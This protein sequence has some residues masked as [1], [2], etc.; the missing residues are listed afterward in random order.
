MTGHTLGFSE[1]QNMASVDLQ[2]PLGH[3]SN[4]VRCL[5]ATG[6]QTAIA[7]PQIQPGT[8]KPPDSP[9]ILMRRGSAMAVHVLER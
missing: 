6:H 8:V 9:T 4:G 7:Q 1:L 5:P 3:T 2:Y